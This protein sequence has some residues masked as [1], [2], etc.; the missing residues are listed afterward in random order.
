MPIVNPRAYV[1][2]RGRE[3]V[4]E[5]STVAVGLRNTVRKHRASGVESVDLPI[6]GIPV[7]FHSN[8]DR[9]IAVVRRAFGGWRAR[10]VSLP[11]PG[12]SHPVRV[13]VLV[14]TSKDGRAD[15]KTVPDRPMFTYCLIDQERVL[16]HTPGSVGFADASCRE[17]YAWVTASLVQAGDCF[18]SGLIEALT[19]AVLSSLDRTPL[20]AAGIVRSGSA[21]LLAGPSGAGK[22]TLSYAALQSG[23]SLLAEDHVNVELDSSFRVWGCSPF[24]HLPPDAQRHFPELEGR[25]VSVLQGKREKLAVEVKDRGHLA[26]AGYVAGDQT[27]ICIL[28]RRKGET[29]G[30]AELQPLSPT[31]IK[32]ALSWGSEA[33]FDIFRHEIAAAVDRLA[34]PGGWRLVL[35]GEPQ[36]AL[37]LLERIVD[38]VDGG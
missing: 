34:R 15:S 5:W 9:V 24:I 12:F 36:D 31:E 18:R 2:L 33:G 7:R 28:E 11:G 4:T 27:R 23:W 35:G 10:D 6:L 1:L 30:T 32:D 29:R 19:F 26:P 20:H 25:K 16:V 13:T 3:T 8:D 17:A 21:V 22:S 14:Q 37:P 38:E